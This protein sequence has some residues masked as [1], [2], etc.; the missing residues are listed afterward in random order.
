MRVLFE[1]IWF[2]SA[3]PTRPL[4]LAEGVEGQESNEKP[5]PSLKIR[6]V[7]IFRVRHEVA[8]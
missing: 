1:P 5:V 4:S 6:E 2:P 3:L 8:D 7:G